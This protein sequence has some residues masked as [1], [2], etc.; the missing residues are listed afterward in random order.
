M[1][2][3]TASRKKVQELGIK[4]DNAVKLLHKVVTASIECERANEVAE[5]ILKGR[6][7]ETL[8]IIDEKITGI[9]KILNKRESLISGRRKED[10][11]AEKS[12]LEERKVRIQK[13]LQQNNPQ[14]IRRWQQRKR[15]LARTLIDENRVKRRKL[16]AGAK[17]SL[18]T[19]DEEFIARSIEETSTAHGRRHHTILYSNH[20]VKKRH[21]LSLANYNL[22]CRG[23]KLIKSST[24][25][26]NRSRPKNI[27]SRAAKGHIGK[28][29]F[30]SKKPAIMHD[31]VASS[32]FLK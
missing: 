16:G 8:N 13:D 19:D 5:D 25:V 15:R 23:K 32:N 17:R 9:D 7:R 6:D 29:L 18:D 24:T 12:S 14:S 31:V 30:C 1:I 22:Q 28:S 11:I 27:N 2:F 10:L 26:L 20:R 4:P 21:F 3:S